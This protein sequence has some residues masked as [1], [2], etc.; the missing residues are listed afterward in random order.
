VTAKFLD[1]RREVRH[2]AEGGVRITFRNPQYQKVEG[3]LVDVS[4]SGFRMSH[5]SRQLMPGQVVEFRHESSGG[6]ARVVW[7]RIMENAVETGFF[8][9]SEKKSQ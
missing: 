1:L 4:D 8:V 6:A 2:P 5:T 3:R 9:L 7:N